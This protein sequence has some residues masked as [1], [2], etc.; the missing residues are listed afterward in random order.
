MDGHLEACPLGY[1]GTATHLQFLGHYDPPGGPVGRV[2]D[3]I[4]LHHLAEACVRSFLHRVADGLAGVN[5]RAGPWPVP[6]P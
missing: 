6:G 2:I 4:A 3:R 5:T 1:K